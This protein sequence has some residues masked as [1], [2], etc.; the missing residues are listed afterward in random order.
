VLTWV[1]GSGGL[2]GR[3]INSASS[4]PFQAETIPWNND[5]QAIQVLTKT[6]KDFLATADRRPWSIVWA[7]GA[8]TTVSGDEQFAREVHVFEQFIAALATSDRL[9]QGVF[10]LISS[11]GGIH[12]GSPNPP[13]DAATPPAPISPYGHAKF[14]QE[15]KAREQLGT[16]LPLLVCRVSNA[17]GPGQDLEKL[18]GL[19]S[20]L[21]LCTYKKEPLHL[22]VPTSTVRDY[23]FTSDIAAQVTAWIEYVRN[24]EPRPRTVVIASGVGTSIAQLVKVAGDVSH[25]RTPIAMG[26][27]PSARNQPLDSRFLPTSVPGVVPSPSTPLPVGVKAVFDDVIDRL[28]QAS[29]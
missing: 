3:A 19:I 10:V 2:I 23:V 6:L 27:H 28:A 4:H 22:F 16:L 26:S 18:Q 5:D 24:T 11:A 17:Y 13:F 29:S 12:A 15:E 25:R 7:A 9:D 14:Q 21:A 8:G 20:R 1:I